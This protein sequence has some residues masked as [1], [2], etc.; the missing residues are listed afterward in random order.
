[1]IELYVEF[2]QHMRLD[3]VGEEVNVDEI[4]D[5]N[6]KE[7][8]NDSEEE[9][10]AN[11]KVDDEN[12]DEDLTGN[13]AVQNEADAIVS[14]HP[15]G[16]S[17][18]M[19]TLDLEAMHALEFS[20]YA[21]MGEGNVV[22]EDDEF[23]VG[24]EF[25]SRESLISAIKSY[26]IS[27]G[28]DYTVYEFEPQTF[29]AKCKGYG[30]RYDWLIRANLIQKKGCWEIRRYNGKHTC[31]METSLQDRAKLDSD[32]IA[33]A[34]R[35]LV[36]AD[37]SI[38]VKSIIVEVQSRF[39]YTVSYRKTWLA[40]QKSV[41]KIFGDWEVSYQTLLVWLK[42]MTMKMPRSCIQIKIV[43]VYRE[44][45]E[46]QGVR[47]LHRVFWNFYPCIVAFRQCKPLVQVDGT[48]LYGKYKGALLVAVAQDRNQNIVLIAFAIV[49]GYSRTKEEYN[50]NYQ[51]LKEWGEAYTQWCDEFGVQRW[52]L[53]FDGG[54][55]WD[56]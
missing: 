39:N 22:A 52:V 29:Y 19:R 1:M 32:T 8:N 43:P 14:Q 47:V 4:G 11:Y 33:D 6:W 2:E 20:K 25:G 49:E 35:P 18:F 36:E 17:S 15:F 24:M 34:I 54:H 26:T 27:R 56:I 48:H 23:S 44:S 21:N 45:E 51:M 13:S 53:A 16:V 46:V 5:T 28:V 3:A 12:D 31:T 10:E 42:A 9:F 55:H 40:K 50:K 41:A 30:A 7:D 38:K 37:L